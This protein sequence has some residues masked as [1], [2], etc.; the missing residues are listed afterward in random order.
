MRRI[1]WSLNMQFAD[2]TANMDD[3][4]GLSLSVAALHSMTPVFNGKD[5]VRLAA[6]HLLLSCVKSEP[7]V[8]ETFFP[9]HEPDSRYVWCITASNSHDPLRFETETQWRWSD[10]TMRY[11]ALLSIASQHRSI[12]VALF[13][14]SHRYIAR[15]PSRLARNAMVLLSCH[16]SRSS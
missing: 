1:R 9:S 2:S 13:L 10:V 11:A 4:G 6:R 15:L 14:A 16:T 3:E 12:A 8:R 7:R 5:I